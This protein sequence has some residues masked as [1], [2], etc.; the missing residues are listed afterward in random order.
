MNSLEEDDRSSIN[1]EHICA[2]SKLPLVILDLDAHLL[3]VISCMNER[4]IDNDD[5]VIG[6]K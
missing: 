6:E 4:F 3:F 1:Y 5:D 2:G